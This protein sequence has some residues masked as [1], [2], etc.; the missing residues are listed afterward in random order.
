MFELLTTGPLIVALV[1]SLPLTILILTINFIYYQ[2]SYHGRS[3]LF[4]IYR[5]ATRYH[6]EYPWSSGVGYLAVYLT[7]TM[8]I[9]SVGV[10]IAIF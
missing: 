2:I 3:D 5:E 6:K 1:L 9:V 8:L 4:D 7:M 10:G